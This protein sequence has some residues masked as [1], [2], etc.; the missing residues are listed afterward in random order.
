MIVLGAIA[1]AIFVVP[2]PWGIA[3]I[4]GAIGIEVL[5]T[6]VWMR[7]LNRLPKRAGPETLIGAGGR[8]VEPC[9]PVGTVR[10]NGETWRAR[11]EVGA[12]RDAPIRVRARDGLTLIVE[13][14]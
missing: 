2:Q 10:V 11:C 9:R 12:D 14:D 8:I 1:L 3:V 6:L 7:V 4:A 5:E 13:P